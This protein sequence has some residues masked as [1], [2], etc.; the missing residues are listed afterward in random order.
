MSQNIVIPN[1]DNKVVLTFSGVDLT[2]ATNLVVTFGTETYS[3]LTTGVTVDSATQMSLDLSGT[4][5]VGQLFIV[6]TYFDGASFN[7]TDITSQELANLSKI[8]VAVG[9]Q[10]I[11]E[12]GSQVVNAN[13]FVSDA[14]YQSYALL[15][16]LT[17]AATQP[18][19]EADLIAAM[20]YLAN[21]EHIMKG[22][23]VSRTQELCYPRYNVMYRGFIVSSSEIPKALRYAQIEAAAYAT[24]SELLSNSSNSNIKSEQIDSLRTEYF[25]GGM[26]DSVNLQRVNAH[27]NGLLEDFDTLVR[28]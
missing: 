17:V 25:S 10:L 23:R 2:L 19:R 7:G 16:G 20:D 27:L 8:I 1:K 3:L 28:T 15:R 9:T 14:E 26:R 5:E 13:S 6:V 11:I 18:E 22:D 4:S 12:D 21:Q 24:S